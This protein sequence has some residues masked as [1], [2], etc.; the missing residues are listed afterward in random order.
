MFIVTLIN[1]NYKFFLRST[2]WATSQDRAQPFETEEAAKLQL[3]KAKK[4]IKPK[5][6]KLAVIEEII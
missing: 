2:V 5:L 3:V 4:F 6:Y 1:D